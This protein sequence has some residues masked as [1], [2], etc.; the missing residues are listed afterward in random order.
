MSDRI[1]CFETLRYAIGCEDGYRGVTGPSYYLNV[2]GKTLF[3]AGSDHESVS[4]L[5]KWS[6][7]FLLSLFP[8]D[9]NVLVL[10]MHELRLQ[11]TSLTNDLAHFFHEH[12]CTFGWGKEAVSFVMTTGNVG[13]QFARRFGLYL[14]T[15]VRVVERNLTDEIDINHYLMNPP[16]RAEKQYIQELKEYKAIALLGPSDFFLGVRS[17]QLD[18]E[19]GESVLLREAERQGWSIK[20]NKSNSS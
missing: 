19:L 2:F 9:N 13:A 11:N 7:D 20:R 5:W 14:D 4:F 15:Y 17:A 8:I 10:D 16:G 6:C 12:K 18:L 1:R 3:S